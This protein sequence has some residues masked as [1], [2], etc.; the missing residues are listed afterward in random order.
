MRDL[1]AGRADAGTA[2][3]RREVCLLFSDIRGFTTRSEKLPPEAV[4]AL[5]NRYF[6]EM[7][8]AIHS[9]GGTVDKFIGDGLM[10]FFGAPQ[11][12]ADP[13]AAVFAAGREMLDRLDRLN[14]ALV[15]EGDEPLAIGIGLHLGP[16]VI[17]N[18]GPAERHEY[19]AIGD[20]VNTCSRVEGLTK[21]LGCPLL[22]TDA[23]AA[24]LPAD[25]GLRPLG[26]V[27]IKG[28][29]PVRVLGWAP[30]AT[31]GAIPDPEG[32]TPCSA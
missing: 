2:G 17:G 29:A 6:E 3:R 25:S 7:V 19:T 31:P 27:P 20:A 21:T 10:A 24:A 23:V 16:A 18:V 14:H 1:L 26:E 15:A 22:V 4:V 30:A 11:A 5:L 9:H 13:A 12:L 32:E 28:R 8:A